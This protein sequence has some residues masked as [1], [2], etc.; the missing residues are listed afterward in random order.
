MEGSGKKAPKAKRIQ[1]GNIHVCIRGNCRRVVFLDEQ[2]KIEFLRRCN[3]AAK[4]FNTIIEAFVIMDNHVH[5]QV[6]TTQ[7]TLFVSRVLNGY[8]YWYNRKYSLSD[9]LF[10]TPFMSYCKYSEEWI[11]NS[12]LYI[13][14]NPVRAFICSHP[15]EYIWSSYNFLFHRQNTIAKYIQ[16]DTSL[17]Y[18]H[19][20]NRSELDEAIKNCPSSSKNDKDRLAKMQ[21]PE[22]VIFSSRSRISL[23][24]ILS[25]LSTILNG[26]NLYN[27][28]KKELEKTV[29]QLRK[30]TGAS[31]TQLSVVFSESSEF[32]R[33]ACTQK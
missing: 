14:N 1:A 21:Y 24:E 33:R 11:I 4:Q 26:K 30:L 19:F 16:I 10:R 15:S 22:Q 17:I 18:R 2:D 32:I 5:L 25:H 13:M 9:K 23:Q 3:T 7:L 20:K 28:E 8:S 27:L 31:Y 12:M 29:Q 6:I